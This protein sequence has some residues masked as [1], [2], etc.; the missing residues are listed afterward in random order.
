METLFARIH[1]PYAPMAWD[2]CMTVTSSTVLQGDVDPTDDLSREVA[3]YISFSLA[4]LLRR[5]PLADTSPARSLATSSPSSLPRGR[6][7]SA[8]RTGFPSLGRTT[9]TPR[10]SSR[11]PTWSASGRSFSTRRASRRPLSSVCLPACRL[12]SSF[13]PSQLRHQE[14][15][16]RP[17]PARPQEV[18]Q[19]GSGCEAPGAGGREEG[20]RRQAQEPQAKCVSCLDSFLPWRELVETHTLPSSSERKDGEGAEEDF[21]VKLEDALSNRPDKAAR[22]GARGGRGGRGDSKVS[23]RRLCL[24]KENRRSSFVLSLRCPGEDVMPSSASA[25]AT[26]APNLTRASRRRTCSAVGDEVVGEDVVAVAVGVEDAVEEDVEEEEVEEPRGL[27]RASASPASD[28][29][30]LHDACLYSHDELSQARERDG[31]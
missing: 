21:D 23:M 15:R 16:G 20:P 31:E 25:E 13:P 5:E 17:S 14:V 29:V 26:N 2:E 22:G 7:L 9:I 10:W 4:M 18:R 24:K 1:A 6:V 12:T 19:E 3:L 27:E 30:A 11:T 28:G 8:L